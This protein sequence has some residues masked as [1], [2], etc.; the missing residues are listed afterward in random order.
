MKI[1]NILKEVIKDIVRK[2]KRRA[3]FAGRKVIKP[4]D[5]EF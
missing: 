1:E 2:A 3:D 4:E 5:I